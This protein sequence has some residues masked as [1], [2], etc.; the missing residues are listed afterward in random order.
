MGEQFFAVKVHRQDCGESWPQDLEDTDLLD[1]SHLITSFYNGWS[2]A[3]MVVRPIIS[4]IALIACSAR[5]HLLLQMISN[6]LL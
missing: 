1:A 2:M 4:D 6:E 5:G 3:A